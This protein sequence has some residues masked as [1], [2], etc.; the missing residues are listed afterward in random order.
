[1]SR[2]IGVTNIALCALCPIDVATPEIINPQYISQ[3][4]NE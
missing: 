1:M 4:I 2:L 3:I